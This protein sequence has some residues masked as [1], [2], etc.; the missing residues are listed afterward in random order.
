MKG[1]AAT[2]LFVALSA[3]VPAAES[4][5]YDP[6]RLG[7]SREEVQAAASH[8]PY[9][10]VG[11]TGG[12]ETRNAQFQGKPITASFAFGPQ[13]LGLIQLWLYEG[14]DLPAA[15]Q[16]FHGAY[17]YLGDQFGALH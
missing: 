2:A 14:Q 7:M 17:T 5:G 16:A 1:A 6:W 12:L 10:P 13:G 11:A 8:G 15:I 9:S 3:A 4:A